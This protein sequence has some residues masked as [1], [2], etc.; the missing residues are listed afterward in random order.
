MQKFTTCL[1]AALW[2]E[3]QGCSVFPLEPRSKKPYAALLPDHSWK[4]F[5]TR[6]ATPEE[7]RHWFAVAPDANL[8][9]VCGSISGVI[10]IDV[11]GEEGQKW[12][13]ENVPAKPNLFQYTSSKSKF[14][15]FYKHPGAHVRVAPSVAV[16]NQIDVRG[17]ASYV[18][19]APSIHPTGAQYSL[20]ALHGFTGMDSLV[21]VP[22]VKLSRDSS[23]EYH[24]APAM[25][26]DGLIEGDVEAGSRNSTLTSICGRLY[27]K[28][29]STEEVVLYAHAWNSQHCKPPLPQREVETIARSM[30]HTHGNNNPHMLNAGGVAHW[31][32]TNN[33]EFTIAD[34]YRD[35]NIKQASDKEK[36]RQELAELVRLGVIEVCGKKAGTYRK[37]VRHLD[38][39]DLDEQQE[40]PLPFW[41]PFHLDR[42]CDIRPG[43]IIVVAG[44]TNS[45][46][47]G[48]LFNIMAMNRERYK[49]NYLSSEMTAGEIKA[50]IQRYNWPISEW[51]QFA[52]F[53]QRSS[54]YHDAIDPDGINIIDFLEVY[55]DFSKIGA[56]IK[57]I[58]DKLRKGI[59]II[60]IQKKKGEDFGRGGEFTLEKAR[61]GISLFT[62]GRLPN[63]IIGSA[64]ITKC[65]NYKPGY[66]P[67][68]KEAFYKFLEGYWYDTE[69]IKQACDFTGKLRFYGDKERRKLI[70]SLDAYCKSVDDQQYQ[71]GYAESYYE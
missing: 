44:E 48:F 49:F 58:F 16:V 52:Q 37:C 45:G 18:V 29:M 23:G 47:T 27:G 22:D 1:E 55:E 4:E 43:N 38:I 63:G 41:L 62:H 13:Q 35:L 10:V 46:K 65:K 36:C 39:I 42:Y 69:P 30:S 7:I 59:A 40:E 70:E 5:Q 60:A 61:L 32:K 71:T 33:G 67:E 25:T 31:V 57:K 56:D 15:A 24:S 19:I 11:D 6:R 26:F 17:D 2:F 20:S 21:P 3:S 51:K 66:N 64:K 28:G 50:R 53:V 14:H 68:G 54:N 12:F 8:A 9:L 34:V